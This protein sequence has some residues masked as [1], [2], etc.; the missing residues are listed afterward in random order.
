MYTY[1]TYILIYVYTYAIFFKFSR[2][3]IRFF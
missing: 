3:N 2:E 1:I